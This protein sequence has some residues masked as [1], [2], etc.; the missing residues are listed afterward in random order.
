MKH[1]AIIAIGAV[2]LSRAALIV[3][4]L[5]PAARL[6][7]EDA[8]SVT[9]AGNVTDENGKPIAGCMCGLELSIASR[10]ASPVRT[11]AIGLPRTI[12]GG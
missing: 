5:L 6:P 3:A 11:V 12:G 4:L 9:I 10:N 8:T 1:D 7:A 2:V